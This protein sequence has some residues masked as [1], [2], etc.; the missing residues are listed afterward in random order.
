MNMNYKDKEMIQV[1]Y[2]LTDDET[3][4]AEKIFESGNFSECSA[5]M[6]VVENRKCNLPKTA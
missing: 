3:D 2:G 6:K 1:I 5:A 4:E